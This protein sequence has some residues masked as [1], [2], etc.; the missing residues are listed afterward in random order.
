MQSPSSVGCLL[1]QHVV[2]AG[3]IKINKKKAHKSTESFFRSIYIHTVD[4]MESSCTA[5][6]EC[7]F[8][9]QHT[10]RRILY[11]YICRRMRAAHL[12]ALY[13]TGFA[14]GVVAFDYTQTE[15]R[16]YD[17]ISFGNCAQIGYRKISRFVQHNRTN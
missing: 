8:K 13:S 11:F 12:T 9:P 3:K 2:G 16:E 4:S 10:C 1:P 15:C 14:S 5:E 17:I 6:C 7:S